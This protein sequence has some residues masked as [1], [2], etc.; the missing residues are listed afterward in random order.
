MENEFRSPVDGVVVEV[1]VKAGTTIDGGT[2]HTG[3]AWNTDAIRNPEASKN[4]E[5]MMRPEQSPKRNS[6]TRAISAR[7]LDGAQLLAR[8]RHGA[9]MAGADRGKK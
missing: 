5:A 8:L 7:P 2:D 6:Q 9:I 4:A 3:V 1:G